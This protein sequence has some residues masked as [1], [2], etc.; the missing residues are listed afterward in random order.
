MD[1]MINTILMKV[2]E[3][4]P[5]VLDA[6]SF[7]NSFCSRYEERNSV[8]NQIIHFSSFPFQPPI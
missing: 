7:Q 3:C 1:L 6:Q 4:K 2:I 8:T 5:A